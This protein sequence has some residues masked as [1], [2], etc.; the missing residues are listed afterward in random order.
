ML[1]FIINNSLALNNY[2]LSQEIVKKWR[3]EIINDFFTVR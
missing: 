3:R 2:C 1:H